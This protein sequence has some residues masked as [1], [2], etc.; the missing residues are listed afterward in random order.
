MNTVRLN[1]KLLGSLCTVLRMSA[2]ELIDLSHIPCTTWYSMMSKIEGITIQQLL[3][4]ANGAHVPVRRFFSFDKADVVGRREDYV[5]EPYLP[6]HYEGDVLKQLVSTNPDAT[7][8]K[9]AKATGMNYSRLKDSMLAVRRTP[10]IRFLTVCEA[11][12]IDPFKIL[13][14]PN[15]EQKKG[16][17]AP[18]VH[19]SAEVT[20]LRAEVTTL[21][22]DINDLRATVATLMAKYEALLA[23]H[24]RLAKRI[25][26][27]IDTINS[28]YIGIAAETQ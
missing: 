22:S 11:F 10:V 20:A 19:A 6:C 24:E 18:A 28:S 14:D 25:N 21:H 9:A 13:I 1:T 15:P 3:A 12:A 5:T 4:I 7:W 17:K 2:S 26:V 23:E 8:Q 16:R 27:N